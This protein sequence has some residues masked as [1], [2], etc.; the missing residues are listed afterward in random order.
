MRDDDDE[1]GTTEAHLSGDPPHPKVHDDTEDGQHAWGE[2]TAERTE[3]LRAKFRRLWL[4]FLTHASTRSQQDLSSVLAA[5]Q[6]AM[7]FGG[8]V[9]RED[10]VYLRFDQTLCV[11][12]DQG[13]RLGSEQVALGP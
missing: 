11:D 7:R 2:D 4:W 8:F 6:V 3:S 1:D 12:I 5:L 10:A 9:K 13:F